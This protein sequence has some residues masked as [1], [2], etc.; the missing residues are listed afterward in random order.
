MLNY[1]LSNICGSFYTGGKL[2]FSDDGNSLFVPINNRINVYDLSSN[3]CNTLLSENRNDLRI[4]AIHPNM[5]ICISIDKFGYGCVINLLK[6]KIIARI[7]FKS[8]TGIITSFNYNNIF[9]PQEEQD[10]VNFS[11]FTN[12]GKYFLVAIGRRVIIWNTPCKHNKYR[13]VKYNDLCYHSLN[14]ISIDISNDD[15]YF[16]TTSYD[17][18]IR[19][20][21][22]SKKKK[23]RPTVLSGN[24]SIIVGAFFSKNRDFIFSVNKSGLIIVWA[25]EVPKTEA[26]EVRGE[27]IVNEEIVDEEI[28]GEKIVGEKIVGEEIVG[29]EIVGKEIVDEEIVNEEIVDEEIV[30]EEIVNE[31]IVNEEVR[32][33]IETEAKRR[34][35]VKAYEKRWCYKKIYYCNQ[36]KNEEVVKA[37]FNKYR[38]LLVIGYSNGK[39]AIYNT[40][41]MTSLYNIRINTNVIDDIVIN[42]DGDWIALAEST[43]GTIIV[44]EWQSESY[45]LKQY[46]SN[47]NVK[48]VKFSPIISHLKI[49]SNIVNNSM[50]YHECDN[51]TSK[52]VIATGN[53]DGTIKLYDYLS[54]INFVTFTAHT[55]SVTDICFLPQGNAF[56]SCS[57][58]GTLR[59]FDLLRY[60]NFKVYTADLLEEDN[61]FFAKNSNNN[62]NESGK[63]VAK[64]ISKKIN[65]QFLCV[66]VNVS[67]NIVAAG[68][69]GNEYIVYIWNIQTGKCIDKL[70]GH[71]SPITKICF[72][73]N[74]KNEGVIATC[75]WGNNILIWDLYSRRNKGSKFEEIMN[76]QSISYMCFDPRGNDILAV[77]TLG[78][79]IN[80]WDISVQ[81]IVG[82]IEGARDIKRGRL[83]GEEYSAIP[84][85]NNNKK[86]RNR[87]DGNYPYVDDLEDQGTNT[88][89]NQNC[90]FTCI[91]YIHN[92]N[93]LA[94]VANTSV[95]LY[96]Y[97]TN[98]YLLVKIIDLTKNYCVDGIKREIS[99]RYLTSEGKHIYEY[100]ISDEEGDIYLDNYKI[101][102]RK[103]KENI[104]PGQVNENFLNNKF[105]KYKLLLNYINI[106]GDD[107]HI[108][109]ASSIGLYIL[110]KD[111]QYYYVPNSKNL[112]KGLLVP[113]N[114][115]PKFLTQNVN[116][117]NFKLSLKKKEY[118]KAFILSLALNN[119]EHILEVYEN[120]PYNLIPLCVKVLTKPFIYIL[121]NFIK[122]L[123]LND[124]IKH[125]HLHLYYLNSIFTIHFSIFIN[126]DFNTVVKNTSGMNKNGQDDKNART[127]IST[128]S[129][130]YRISLLFILKQI[131]TLYN[132]LQYLYT[133]NI[134]VLKYLSLDYVP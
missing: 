16:L 110:T 85:M 42:K 75:S 68:G 76:S 8:K 52:F 99:S 92:G 130:E 20:H 93:Y 1:N 98:I 125:I 48:C 34:R 37:C 59:A 73:T 126:S 41:E 111:H 3:T 106:S 51:F 134:N 123:L 66:N 115:D 112:Y 102:N 54:Y 46:T 58:D 27:E 4:I 74:L 95:S 62:M 56:I 40:P 49:G 96:I 63:I 55:N 103:K 132:G 72:S 116:V 67:G 117:K 77:C 45:I 133:N 28:V 120:V 129:D 47:K 128:I 64:K 38:D 118:I 78:C 69:R 121:I 61:N 109:V 14:I 44:W 71:N 5:D 80:F 90:Y 15:E 122:T 17:L 124:T 36:D 24:K 39:F 11:T 84:K 100:D 83:L 6:D 9:T 31:E 87:K 108:A 7:L 12:S 86:K 22:I 26:E 25:Y 91:D 131:I 89:V 127:S 30:N 57:L 43:N 18:T 23:I 88:V 50:S 29:K 107:R 33:E 13:L 114:Y 113:I 101:L 104:L 19:I 79:K 82:T 21:T 65:V 94:G 119:Y 2:A 10:F 81:E 60:R 53:E 32:G 70:Y 97:D 35:Y 105:K